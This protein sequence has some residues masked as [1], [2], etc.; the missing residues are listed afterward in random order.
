MDN[1]QFNKPIFF[2]SI[3]DN[4]IICITIKN[5]NNIIG[6]D[7]SKSYSKFT[8]KLLDI[9]NEY[10][11]KIF[12]NKYYDN[13]NFLV[14]EILINRKTFFSKKKKMVLVLYNHNIFNKYMIDLYELFCKNNLML[15]ETYMIE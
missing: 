15:N 6:L 4:N 3:L 14:Y 11:K 1:L 5:D 7:Y 8:G 10:Y 2:K 9:K 13:K 12:D